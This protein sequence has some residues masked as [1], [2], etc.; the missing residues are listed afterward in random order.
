[1][2]VRDRLCLDCGNIWTSPVRQSPHN[3]NLSGEPKEWCSAC[4]SGSCLSSSVYNGVSHEL[5]EMELDSLF[6]HNPWASHPTY[7]VADWQYEVAN[8]DTRQGYR[9]WLYNKLANEEDEPCL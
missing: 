8:G 1:M 6:K 3:N 4:G 9:G 2:R 5:I 7:P